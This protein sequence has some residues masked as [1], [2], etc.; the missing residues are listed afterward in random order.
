MTSHWLSWPQTDYRASGLIL[1]KIIV[2]E[3]QVVNTFTVIK[4]SLLYSMG[5]I[6]LGRR[7]HEGENNWTLHYDRM[8]HRINRGSG[9]HGAIMPPLGMIATADAGSI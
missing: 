8:N 5:V 4:S 3:A 2:T 9:F 1:L 7:D 6:L